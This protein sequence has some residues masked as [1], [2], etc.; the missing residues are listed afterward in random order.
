MTSSP[1]TSPGTQARPC[2]ALARRLRWLSMAPFGMPGRA[3]R[4]L[5]E[6]RCRPRPAAGG[7]RSSGRGAAT[8]ASHARHAAAPSASWRPA[9]SGPWRRAAA[10]R[11]AWAAAGPRVR[12]DREDGL[13][14][15]ARRDLGEGRHVLSHAMATV[16]PWSANWWRSSS[17]CTAGC[18]RRRSRR[19]AAPRRTRP[20]AAGSWAARAR[21]DRP[22]ATPRSSQ[23]S[24]RPCDLVGELGVGRRPRRRS[25]GRSCPA[26]RATAS[27]RR[28]QR[29][30]SEGS[31]SDGTPGGV[32]GEPRTGGQVG[33]RECLLRRCGSS[34]TQASDGD[35][36]RTAE[37]RIE[38]PLGWF[39]P[40]L[41]APTIRK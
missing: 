16:A 18:A 36:C 37:S 1:S 33:H 29:V 11:A 2:A 15:G 38:S 17:P 19:A 7:R 25:R 13:E 5:Q 24:G 12:F 40:A 14:R 30:S 23:R 28:S 22:S 31:M 21:R 34:L 20:R 26:N 39:A 8:I 35:A 27:S 41:G 6:R 10:A 4:V 3:A 32:L 9:S